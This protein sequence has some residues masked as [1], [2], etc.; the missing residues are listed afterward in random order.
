VDDILRARAEGKLAVGI[1]L[2]WFLPWLSPFQGPY[3][4]EELSGGDSANDPY[5]DKSES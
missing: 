3:G 1:H 4:W 2:A 5:P